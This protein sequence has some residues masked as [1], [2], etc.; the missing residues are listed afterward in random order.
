MALASYRFCLRSVRCIKAPNLQRRMKDNIREMFEINSSS[1][2]ETKKKQVQNAYS[3]G[4]FIAE[5]ENLPPEL[6][7]ELMKQI[8]S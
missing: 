1:S 4:K 8:R 3:F 5:L 6:H 7:A 2:G